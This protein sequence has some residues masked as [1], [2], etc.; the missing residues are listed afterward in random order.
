MECRKPL[1]DSLRFVSYKQLNL[2]EMFGFRPDG[3]R[4]KGID[5]IQRIIPHIMPKRYDAQNML[6]RDCPCEP[7]DQFIYRLFSRKKS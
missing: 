6:H 5:P 4:L 1:I 2:Y 7:M 3:I